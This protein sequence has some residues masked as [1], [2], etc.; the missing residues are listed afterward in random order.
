MSEVI[1]KKEDKVEEKILKPV[2]Y[3]LLMSPECEIGKIYSAVGL[4]M[5]CPACLDEQPLTKEQVA[6]THKNNEFISGI[7][8]PYG[9]W[10]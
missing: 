9:S 3:A 2:S 8:L 1:T 10:E 4:S 7:I 5:W 6:Q